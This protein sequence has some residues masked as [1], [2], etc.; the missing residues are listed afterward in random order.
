[1]K[2]ITYLFLFVAS[3]IFAFTSCN[4][5][6]NEPAELTPEQAQ[7]EIDKM[8]VEMSSMVSNMQNGEAMQAVEEFLQ[9]TKKSVLKTEEEW[10]DNMFE[11]LSNEINFEILESELDLDRKFYFSKYAGKYSWNS[12]SASWD[13]T[14]SS[15]II[16]EFPA[17]EN[18]TS[19]NVVIT[20][21]SYTDEEVTI[22]GESGW[23]PVSAHIKLEKD[24]VKLIAIDLNDAAYSTSIPYVNNFDVRIFFAPLTATFNFAENSKTEYFAE[25]TLSD[26]ENTVGANI[27]LSLLKDLDENFDENYLKLIS[28][29]LFL[30]EL[31]VSY[32]ANMEN[33]VAYT[34]EPTQEQVNRD[35]SVDVYYEEQKIAYLLLENEQ[36]YVVY[37]NGDKALAEEEFE[38]L[39]TALENLFEGENTVVKK[40]SLKKKMKIYK[41]VRK[42][43]NTIEF[44][45]S[46]KK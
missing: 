7:E 14:A 41:Q 42:F 4:P 33:I 3:L 12:T 6:E 31:S 44:I 10:F 27:T 37:N 36:I 28:G 24:G 29:K 21:E 39:I 19:N 9:I 17:T 43:K 15:S 13:K 26:G 46:F 32:S 38:A 16:L 40:L 45:K 5:D 18:S 34:E 1:M 20:F 25:K 35:I 8:A 23:L 22:D 11:A 30:N 2:K